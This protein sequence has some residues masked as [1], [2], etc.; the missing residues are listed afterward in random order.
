M[1]NA[2]QLPA[3]FL[4]LMYD[5]QLIGELALRGPLRGVPLLANERC[6][7]WHVPMELQVGPIV[8]LP[9]FQPQ[10]AM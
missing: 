5:A 8:C 1:Q 3:I 9:L 4:S 10:F 7:C 2:N 6:G